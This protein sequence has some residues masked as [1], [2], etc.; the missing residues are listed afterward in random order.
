MI[1]ITRPKAQAK[2]LEIL[3]SSKG[4]KTYQESLYDFKYYMNKVSYDKNKYY[5]F[6]SIHS[7]KSL[8]KSKQIYKFK[9]ANIFA[10]GEKVKQALIKSGCNKILTTSK[11]SDALIKILHTPKYYKS[12][13]IYFGSNFTNKEFFIRAKRYKIN[14]QKKTVYKTLPVK[15]LTSDL[16]NS[17]KLK[18]VRGIIFYSVLSVDI[19]LSLLIKYQMLSCMKS[20]N[21]Y[22]LSERIAKPLRQNKFK[23]I[24]IAKQPNQ[25]ALLASIKKMHFK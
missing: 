20:I 18:K 14:I 11:D 21:S 16:I 24:Y 10:I 13:F 9:N 6:P 23:Y 25:L 8:V 22:C 19:L 12:D 1:L 4:H 7:I 5:I 17:L 3:I 15:K 2:N